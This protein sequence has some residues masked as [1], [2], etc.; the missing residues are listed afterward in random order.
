MTGDSREGDGNSGGCCAFILGAAGVIVLLGVFAGE[1]LIVVA[2][3]LIGAVLLFFAYL[4]ATSSKTSP[5]APQTDHGTPSNLTSTADPHKR[6]RTPRGPSGDSW[7]P[8]VTPSRMQKVVGEYYQQAT[9]AELARR[10]HIAMNG[11]RIT[12]DLSAAVELD[13]GNRH[14][15]H[16]TAIT[17]WID[18]LLAGYLPDDVVP[19]YLPALRELG[20]AGKHISMAAR[21][22]ITYDQRKRQWRPNLMLRLPSSASILPENGMIP[23]DG[24]V[25]PEGR[26][27]Q[28]T[29]EERD[30]DVLEPLADPDVTLHYAATLRRV[31]EKRPRST[32]QSVEVAINGERVGALT[33]TM[34]DQ[35]LPLVDMICD[36][37]RVPYARATATVEDK[38]IEVRLRIIRYAEASPE[39][40]RRIGGE[41]PAERQD[42]EAEGGGV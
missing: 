21:L 3:I 38:G 24:E 28:V 10:H 26:T 12:I 20:R 32:Y 5:S 22:Y 17:V 25:I 33:K 6:T 14:A 29:G 39:W 34:A 42:R 11:D 16:G 2:S 15:R 27:V 13:P 7:E 4:F 9:Y 36:A 23:A 35:I 41:A 37:G 19:D 18:G 1:P 30:Q 8:W 40:T 31:S